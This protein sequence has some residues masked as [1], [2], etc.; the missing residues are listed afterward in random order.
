MDQFLKTALALGLILG[1][2]RAPATGQ[3]SNNPIFAGIELGS[4]GI[5]AIAIR[6]AKTD[7]AAGARLVS[8]ETIDLSLSLNGSGSSPSQ[9]AEKAAAAVEKL[10]QQLKQQYRVPPEQTYIFGRSGIDARLREALTSAIKKRSEK[11]VDFLDQAT[12][13]QLS[14]VGIIPKRERVGST[15]FDN[16]GSSVLIEVGNYST[17]GGYEVLRYSPVANYD[18]VTMNVPQ[19]TVSFTDEVV[20]AIGP[21]SDWTSLAQRARIIGSDSVRRALRDEIR[22]KPGLLNRKHVYLTGGIVEAL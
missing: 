16:R 22:N 9:V 18:F 13:T 7:D 1:G 12:E 19:G 4:E 15:T 10:L 3:S 6:I 5:Q 14:I 2:L 17:R 21:G 20:K 8:S 11:T